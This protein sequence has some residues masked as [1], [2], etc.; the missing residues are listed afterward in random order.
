MNGYITNQP[1]ISGYSP[2]EDLAKNSQ[3]GH[4]H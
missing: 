3:V 1:P 2:L 4:K